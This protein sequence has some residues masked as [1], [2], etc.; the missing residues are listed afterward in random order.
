MTATKIPNHVRL[1]SSL[2]RTGIRIGTMI[3]TIG[4]HS[5]GQPRRKIKAIMMIR[6]AV[7]DKSHANKN[8]VSIIG[9]PSREN[10]APKKF[11][12]ATRNRIKTEI[13]SVLIKAS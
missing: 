6:T 12:A 8:S 2:T 4:T 1:I 11:D 9:V 13:S 3:N 7:A 5:S 10:T